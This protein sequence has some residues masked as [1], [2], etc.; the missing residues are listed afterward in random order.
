MNTEA[1]T[2]ILDPIAQKDLKA[3]KHNSGEVINAILELENNPNKGHDL[4]GNLQ[5]AKALEFSLKGSGQYRAAYLVLERRRTCIVFAIGP[6]ENFYDFAAKKAKQLKPL[7]DEVR[8]AKRQAS[9]SK[10]SS[11]S[12]RPE[13][14]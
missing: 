5:G 4:A 13:D 12:K 6:R 10:K 8:E 3:F 2:V 11:R 14:A 9:A 7:M 1:Y